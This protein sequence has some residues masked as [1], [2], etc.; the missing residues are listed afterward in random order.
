MTTFTALAQSEPLSLHPGCTQ[1]RWEVGE[2][3]SRWARGAHVGKSWAGR[4]WIPAPVAVLGPSL[5]AAQSSYLPLGALTGRL[6]GQPLR[7]QPLPPAL[8]LLLGVLSAPDLQP[9]HLVALSP[10]LSLQHVHL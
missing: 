4:P 10:V 2:K 3:T 9:A 7:L 6:R 1:P 8:L 5:Q